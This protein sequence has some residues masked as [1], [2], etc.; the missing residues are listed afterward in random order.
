MAFNTLREFNKC[1]IFPLPKTLH[2]H[3]SIKPQRGFIYKSVTVLNSCIIKMYSCD[4]FYLHVSLI[5][6]LT[7]VHRNIA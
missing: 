1:P 3:C 7:E 5:L 4:W 6:G 2:N